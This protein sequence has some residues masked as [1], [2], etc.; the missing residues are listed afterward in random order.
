MEGGTA[1][2]GSP[3]VLESISEVDAGLSGLS[4]EIFS[5][6]PLRQ[7]SE[8]AVEQDY[9]EDRKGIGRA[10]VPPRSPATNTQTGITVAAQRDRSRGTRWQDVDLAPSATALTR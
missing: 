10:F 5:W 6:C 8:S 1:A 7:R 4:T 2:V 9:E 3:T